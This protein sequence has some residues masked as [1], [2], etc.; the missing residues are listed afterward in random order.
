MIFLWNDAFEEN[1]NDGYRKDEYD[2][3]VVK[4]M[5]MMSLRRG[6]DSYEE[7]E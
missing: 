3:M 5:S 6:W 1:E 7:D 2:M 4:S